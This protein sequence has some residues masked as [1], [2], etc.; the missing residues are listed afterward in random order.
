MG[1]RVGEGEAVLLQLLV[2]GCREWEDRN[3][4]LRWDRNMEKQSPAL[5]IFNEARKILH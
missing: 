5:E 2:N 4:P 3:E 1:V